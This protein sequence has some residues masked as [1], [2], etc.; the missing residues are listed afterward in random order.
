MIS[1]LKFGSGQMEEKNISDIYKFIP[2]ISEQQCWIYIYK[3][4]TGGI[5]ANLTIYRKY[6]KSHET[7][8]H[9]I[10]KA[11]RKVSLWTHEIKRGDEQRVNCFNHGF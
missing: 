9:L 4:G 1:R 7:N 6:W 10:L 11:T 3:D 2:V 5:F 8:H